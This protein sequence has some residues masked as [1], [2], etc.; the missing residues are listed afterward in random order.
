[1]P[2]ITPAAE[3]EKVPLDFIIASPLTAAVKAQQIAAETT[4]NFILSFL[5][6]EKSADGKG[7]GLYSPQT[8]K[9]KLDAKKTNERG[10]TVAS[11]V[12]L[13]VPILSMVPVPHLRIDSL[14]THFKYE[15]TQIIKTSSESTKTITG[16]GS[17]GLKVIPILNLSLSGTLSS[18]SSEDASTNRSGILE[19]TVHASEAPIPEGLARLLSMLAKVAEPQLIQGQ[20]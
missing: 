5:N 10:E 8:V 3:F 2:D 4:K 7:T 14:T 13:D 17:A 9:F 19:V 18:R 1:M 6:E 11:N 12:N 20:T 16:S 15:V